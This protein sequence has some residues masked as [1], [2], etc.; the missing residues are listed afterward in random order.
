LRSVEAR[1]AAREERAVREVLRL[2]GRADLVPV[3]KRTTMERLAKVVFN[4]PLLDELS[5]MPV[6]LRYSRLAFDYNGIFMELMNDFAKTPMWAAWQD[7]AAHG[8]DG[9]P[10]ALVFNWPRVRGCRE[11][12]VLHNAA[13]TEWTGTQLRRRVGDAVYCIETLPSFL[14]GTGLLASTA[15]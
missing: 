2:T 10:L 8:V 3:I 4:F 1:A 7:A 13:T 6:A 9:G 11:L 5:P 15:E 12:C 14:H